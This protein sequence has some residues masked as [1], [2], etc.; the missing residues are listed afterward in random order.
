MQLINHT[1]S[2]MSVHLSRGP[3]EEGSTAQIGDRTVINIQAEEPHI[4][5][6]EG[7]LQPQ[8]LQEKAAVQ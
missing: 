4:S 2:I 5:S 1:M 3:F 6:M 7:Q 8:P